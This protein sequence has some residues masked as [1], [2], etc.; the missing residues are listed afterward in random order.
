MLSN[1][2]AIQRKILAIVAQPN[3]R[4]QKPRKFLAPLGLTADDARPLRLLIREM[5]AKGLLAYGKGH[6]V[7]ACLPQGKGSPKRVVRPPQGEKAS[8]RVAKVYDTQAIIRQFDLPEQFSRETLDAA[9]K[10]LAASPCDAA[11]L[12]AM[13]RVDLTNELVITID[14]AD[15]KD[16][17]DALSLEKLDDGNWRLGIHIADVAHFVP[18]NSPIDKEARNRATSIYLPDKV[19]PMLPEVLSNS[20]ASLQPGEIRLAKTVYI[21]Y[22]PAGKRAYIEIVR[23]A[24]KSRQRFNYAEVQDF[25]DQPEK[26]QLQWEPEIQELLTN[27]LELMH[28]LRKKRFDRG[29]LELDI[30]EPKVILDDNG[31][32]IGA[33]IAPYYN[34]NRIVEECMLAANEA[35]A[36]MLASKS[37]PFLRRV[38][39]GPNLM[40]LQVFTDFVQSLGFADLEPEEIYQDRF[41]IQR[42]LERVRGTSQ[43]Y[44]VNLSL[45][46]SMQKAVYSPDLEG[47]YALASS[48]YCHFTSPIR[49]Y[50]DLL[51]HRLIDEV[52]FGKTP[53]PNVKELTALGEHCSEREQRAEG[54]ERELIKLKLIDYM[55]RNLGKRM[56]AVITS[57]ESFGIFVMGLEIPAEGLIHVKWLEDDYY[58]FE[59]LAKILLG[60]RS[61]N[62]FRIG[63][64][65]QVQAV[66]ADAET[67]RIDFRLVKRLRSKGR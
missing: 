8:K 45:L 9:E 35:V 6:H 52:L 22:T 44:A 14:P 43:E 41:L 11:R 1:P 2:D 34:S 10:L 51:V 53:K 61:G 64:R 38:H 58:R 30:P 57:V 15:A 54:A 55:N 59:S 66:R 29:A 19:I 12:N 28:V 39:E 63:D 48:C 42:L 50:P 37:I 13:Q 47:H 46:R 5:V 62:V 56:E 21:E 3:Y 49:R 36:E 65:L 32:V 40:K 60:L 18:K 20:L 26:Y 24:I 31:I 25:F 27:L 17:D 7:E 23:S 16:F 4:P 33:H 67:R